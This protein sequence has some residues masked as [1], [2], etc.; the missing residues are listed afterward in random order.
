MGTEKVEFRSASCLFRS[1]AAKFVPSLGAHCSI[2][3]MGPAAGVWSVH[4]LQ[5]IVGAFPFNRCELRSFGKTTPS[6]HPK[7]ISSSTIPT[8]IPPDPAFA[9]RQSL[10]YRQH[11]SDVLDRRPE[12]W[13]ALGQSAPPRCCCCCWLLL[14]P[15]R[16]RAPAAVFE[17]TT[18]SL[19]PW[20]THW[21]TFPIPPSSPSVSSPC[22]SAAPT[23]P[24]AAPAPRR[25]PRPL[26]STPPAPTRRTSSSTKPPPPAY[27]S[28]L[29][30]GGQADRTPTGS[31]WTKRTRTRRSRSTKL[32]GCVCGRG[33]MPARSKS[34]L[35]APA[36][37]TCIDTSLSAS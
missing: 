15:P 29:P 33:Q 36:S 7:R 1:T 9:A 21:L 34:P 25:S 10:H 16:P 4:H 30:P 19:R 6:R 11:G 3:S 26:P 18:A 14:P 28:P 8:P 12:G 37:C 32:E 27:L 17:M 20:R 2:D 22:S 24:S 31:S 23:L 5:Q 35:V 13:L